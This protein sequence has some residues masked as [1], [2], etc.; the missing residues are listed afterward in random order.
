MIHS[1]EDL[2]K[3]LVYKMK[4]SSENFQKHPSIESK[5]KQRRGELIG[6]TKKK[7][8]NQTKGV[9]SRMMVLSKPIGLGNWVEVQARGV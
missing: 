8:P 5:A 2:A 9:V 6:K 4:Y 1:H 7:N 3:N